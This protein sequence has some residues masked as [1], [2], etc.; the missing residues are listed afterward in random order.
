MAD[1]VILIFVVLTEHV[2]QFSYVPKCKHFIVDFLLNIM[3]STF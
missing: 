3:I 1:T 2:W